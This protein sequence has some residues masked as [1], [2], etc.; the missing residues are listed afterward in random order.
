MNTD[1]SL[2]EAKD[3]PIVQIC[4][5]DDWFEAAKQGATLSILNFMREYKN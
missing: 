1:F 3:D 2:T 5:V 4:R